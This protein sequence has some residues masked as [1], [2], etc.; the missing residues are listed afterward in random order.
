MEIIGIDFSQLVTK[1]SF[2]QLVIL[3]FFCTSLIG[4]GIIATNQFNKIFEGVINDTIKNLAYYIDYFVVM[5][6][7]VFVWCL[8]FASCYI[9]LLY[10]TSTMR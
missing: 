6:L 3:T 10:A 4:A 7:I 9:M 2:G 1:S 5:F 8:V